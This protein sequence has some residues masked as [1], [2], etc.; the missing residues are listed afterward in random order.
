M[1]YVFI[2]LSLDFLHYHGILERIKI[3]IGSI[4]VYLN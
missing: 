4:F 1:F 3:P 2:S